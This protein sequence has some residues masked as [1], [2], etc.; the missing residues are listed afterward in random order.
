MLTNHE[1]ENYADL[2]LDLVKDYFDR[3]IVATAKAYSATF[4]TE[5]TKLKE[6]LKRVNEFTTLKISTWNQIVS[7]LSEEGRK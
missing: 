3:M 1:I 7:M 4:L 5:D 2:L 6:V